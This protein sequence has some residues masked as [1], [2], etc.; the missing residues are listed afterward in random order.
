MGK[1]LLIVDP[2]RDF[3]DEGSLPVK[4]SEERMR[5]LSTYLSTIPYE[6]YDHIIVTLDWHPY[7]HCSFKENGGPW[8]MHCVEFTEGA[9]VTEPL[10]ENLIFWANQNKLTFVTK[11]T[12]ISKEEYS[13]VQNVPS[14]SKIR[15]YLDEST[16]IDVCGV[17]GT[18][19]VKNTLN[20]LL[21]VYQ[22]RLN[23]LLDYTAQFSAEDEISFIEWLGERNI[24]CQTNH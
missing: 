16:Q 3:M 7:K 4:G 19:C 21:C 12:T 1:I 20:D 22:D 13:I 14:F 17:V 6:S 23:V 10:L 2:Q 5:N 18:V 8:P 24:K 15:K 9:L 11:G